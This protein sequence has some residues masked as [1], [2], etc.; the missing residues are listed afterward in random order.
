[1]L[2]RKR[3][4]KGI[5]YWVLFGAALAIG[6][7]GV[8]IFIS[9]GAGVQAVPWAGWNPELRVYILLGLGGVVIG[10]GYL[11]RRVRLP[12]NNVGTEHA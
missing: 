9:A 7:L 3:R 10:L 1:M 4:G 6:V 2:A 5:Q 8:I 12:A 11:L